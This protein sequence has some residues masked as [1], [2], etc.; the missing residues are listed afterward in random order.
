MSIKHT[1]KFG[2]YHWDSFDNNTILIGQFERIDESE[3][4]VYNKYAGR[5]NN[6]GADRVD[7]VDQYGNVISVFQVS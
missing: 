4:F 1:K 2:V 3:Q 7:I 5:I 6:N